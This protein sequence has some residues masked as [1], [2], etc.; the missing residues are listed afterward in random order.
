MNASNIELIPTEDLI[1]E[2]AKRCSP[3]IFI[4]TKY[5]YDKVPPDFVNFSRWQGNLES[6][7]GLCAEMSAILSADQIKKIVREEYEP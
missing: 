6:C 7:I 1:S 3:M 2:L 4:G 5:Q